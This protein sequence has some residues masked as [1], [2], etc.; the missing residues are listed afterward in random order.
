MVLIHMMTRNTVMDRMAAKIMIIMA[1]ITDTTTSMIIITNT[2]TKKTK[3]RR[4]SIL[5]VTHMDMVV[6]V[7]AMKT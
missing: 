7:T 6:T 4:K 5:T 2:I 3:K 1:T